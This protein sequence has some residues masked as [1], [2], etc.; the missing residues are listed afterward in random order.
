MRKL[1]INVLAPAMLLAATTVVSSQ[2]PDPNA[3]PAPT[4]DK[5]APAKSQLEQMLEIA[6]KSNPDLRVADAKAREADA[7]L[8]RAR[9]AVTRKVVLLYN[10]LETA[11]ANVNVAEKLAKRLRAMSGSGGVAAQD[12]D[13]AEAKLVQAKA[14]LAK[15]EA[16][17]P[18]LL[19]QQKLKWRKD[20]DGKL[21][22][23]IEA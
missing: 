21:R 19:G 13:E 8:S 10:N 14:E 23:V 9:L 12:L 17:I 3:K 15:L 11:R 6:L 16:E 22:L 2:P 20:A 7:E 5:E 18:Y 4:K 1:W